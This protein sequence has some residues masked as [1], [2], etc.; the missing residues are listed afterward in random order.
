VIQP[1]ARSPEVYGWPCRLVVELQSGELA[2]L[3]DLERSSPIP[4]DLRSLVTVD[5]DRDFPPESSVR[6]SLLPV[7]RRLIILKIEAEPAP[8]ATPMRA[9]G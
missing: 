4:E 2:Y 5:A 8:E 3:L 1:V 6:V 7:F 9:Y